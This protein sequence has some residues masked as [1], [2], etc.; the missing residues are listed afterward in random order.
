M[1]DYLEAYARRFALPVRTGV[2][3]ERV[4][5]AGGGLV[6]ETGSG[7]YRCAAVVVASGAHVRP[8][9]PAFARECDPG[10]TQLHSLRYRGPAQL[11]PGGVL[12]VGAANSGTDIALES[13]AAGHPTWLAGRHP[14]QVPVDI[15]RRSAQLL[16]PVVMFVHR[17]FLTLGTP[18]GRRMAERSRGHG[19]GLVRNKFADLEAAGVVRL[20]RITGVQ[21]G[22]PV[23][24]DGTVP[25]VATVVWST[26]STPDHSFLDLPV[27]APDGTPVRDRGVAA[28]P[29][30]YFLGLEFQYALASASLPGLDRDARHVVRHLRRHRTTVAEAQ[31][32]S[33]GRRPLL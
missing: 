32:C 27:F 16:M 31:P 18:L 2:R 24:D 33:S 5:R 30:V 14:G 21:A 10:L 23:A 4:A 19:V 22:R 12:V 15:D 11:A 26:G 7:R 29:G 13:A 6:V 17:N 20:G 3:V 8:V 28:E 25:D 1:A 9:V